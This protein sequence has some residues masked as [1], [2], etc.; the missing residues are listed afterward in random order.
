MINKP[1]IAAAV[2][3]AL[4]ATPV[5]AQQQQGQ[6]GQQGQQQGQQATDQKWTQERAQYPGTQIFLSTA[7]VRQIQQALNSQGYDAGDVDG[8]W[9]EGTTQAAQDYQRSQGLEP[10]G[11][12]TVEMINALGLNNVLQGQMAQGQQGQQGLQWRQETAQ[13]QGIPV[14]VSTAYVRQIQQALNERGYDVGEVDGLW[15]ESTQQAAENFQRANGLE[16]NGRLDVNLL[17]ELQLA[18]QILGAGQQGQGQQGQQQGQQG[19]QALQW[20][21][22]NAVSEG[23]PL[24]ASPA[25]VR[26]IEVSLNSNGY[27]AGNV[28]GQWDDATT[29]A[30]ENYQRSRGLEPTG[31]LTTEAMASLDI[32]LLSGGQQQG[33]QQ[34]QQGQRGQQ[35]MQG[36]Q[37]QQRQQGGQQQQGQS[38]QEGRQQ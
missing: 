4:F 9:D 7:S 5:V 27:D 2:S 32:D 13:G 16:P 21:Q 8:Q 22:E 28:D 12:P 31:S 29:Q 15:G 20:T 25:T 3:A 18:Q 14:Y 36:Q 37:G 11:T 26:Q 34:G 6:Q 38:Q 35:G 33:Q 23:T 17:S 10:T 19:Q 24:W 30:I 1:L